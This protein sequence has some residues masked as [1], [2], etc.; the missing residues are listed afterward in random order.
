M[1]LKLRAVFP[2]IPSSNLEDV[3]S[4]SI[5]GK[6]FLNKLVWGNWIKPNLNCF[7]Y[8]SEPQIKLSKNQT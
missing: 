1:T 3:T 8:F 5:S 4:Y 2:K 7:P 6:V